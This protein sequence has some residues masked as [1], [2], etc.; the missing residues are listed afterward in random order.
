MLRKVTTTWITDEKL[1]FDKVSLTWGDNTL[2]QGGEH[3]RQK[4]IR[5]EKADE[6]NQAD[7][8]RSETE[9]QI[10]W[11]KQADQNQGVRLEQQP[12]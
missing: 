5:D 6:M 4:Q 2:F 1:P 7:Q 12:R 3:F 10:R 11:T 9:R 8:G